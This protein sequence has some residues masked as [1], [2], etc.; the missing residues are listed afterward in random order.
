MQTEDIESLRSRCEDGFWFPDYGDRS[1]ARVTPTVGE[2]LDR[3]LGPTLTDDVFAGVD[4]GVSN[5]VLL[6]VDGFGYDCW[7]R[8]RDRY[9]F[10]DAFEREGAVTPL[11]SI[12][13]SETAAA[14]T[15]LHTG[16]TAAE[17]G[18]LGWDQYVPE[19]ETVVE[20]LPFSV[21]GDD[22]GSAGEAVD[23]TDLFEGASLFDRF[24]E[25]GVDAH[26]FAKP[27]VVEG[28]YSDQVMGASERHAQ[29]TVAARA[30]AV[31]ETLE[32][33]GG[34]TYCY[35]YLPGV[36]SAAHHAGT[37]SPHYQAMLAEIVDAF[38]RQLAAL[39]PDVAEETLVCLTADHGH[40]DTPSG[41]FVDLYEFD[42]VAD[43]LATRSDGRTI[44]PVGGPRLAHL[45]L[46][47]GTAE[48][49]ADRLDAELDAYV[50]TGE[51]AFDRELFGPDPCETARRRTGDVLVSHR[52][53]NVWYA[54]GTGKM[55]YVG[56]HG[57]L[58]EREV[59]V[60]FAAAK[61]SDLG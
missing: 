21:K 58:N 11:T 16:R 30:L 31:R 9:D 12:A 39:D 47:D 7:Q 2:V 6:L 50:A 33:A 13:P 17:H 56:F 20:P 52:E 1:F 25:S 48:Y 27:S 61:A 22:D 19:T 4:T 40:V 51:D 35:A 45:H 44:P 57:G 36:D 3:D 32:T 34:Q 42:A 8:D 5:V 10:L 38:G 15:T 54:D 37:E 59:V 41:E 53:K 43:N 60:P 24:V 49:V 23:P 28:G 55:G 18:L 46:E 26:A 14:I 29:D